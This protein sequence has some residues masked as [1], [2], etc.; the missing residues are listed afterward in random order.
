MK[1]RRLPTWALSCLLLALS[2]PAALAQLQGALKEDVRRDLAEIDPEEHVRALSGIQS[3][4]T[5]Y[6]GCKEAEQYVYK[7][8]KQLGLANLSR[9]PFQ[10]IVPVDKGAVLRVAGRRIE[11]FSVRP[12]YVR[13]PKTG[14][15]GVS[16]PIIWG[17]EGRLADFNGKTVKGSV[18]IMEF[19]SATRWL[20]AAKLGAKAIVFIEPL[21]AFRSDAEQKYSQ[22]PA[23]VPRYY[24]ERKHLPALAAAVTGRGE[25]EFDEA[26]SL[27]V[28]HALSAGKSTA[29]LLADMIWEESTVYMLS[30]EVPGTDPQL[31]R[32]VLVCHAYYDS[33]SVVPALAPGAESACGISA[34]LEIAEF[35]LKHPPRR[36]VKLLA[37]PGH[38][39]ALAGVREYAFRTIYPHR[40]EVTQKGGEREGEPHFFIGLDLSSRHNSLAGFYKGHFYDQYEKTNE[41]KLQRIYADYSGLLLDWGEQVA[42]PGGVAEKLEFQSGIVPQ[43]GRDWRSLLPDLAAFDAEVITLSAHP[44]ITLATTGDPRNAVNTPLDTFENMEPFLANVRDQAVACAHIVKQTADIP[45]IPINDQLETVK[46]ASIFG[47]AIEQTLHAYVPTVNVPDAVAGINLSEVK[48]MMGVK[49]RCFVRSDAQGLF[50]VF[51]L[52]PGMQFVV[53][54][55]RLSP[56]DG[57]IEAVATQEL[58]KPSRLPRKEWDL[59]ETDLRLNF[60]D[61]VST[62]IYDL[63]DPLQ[64]MLIPQAEALRGESNSDVQYMVKFVG[65]G[66][67][68][69]S[70]AEPVAVFF[71]KRDRRLKFILTGGLAGNQGV[72]LNIPV[73]LEQKKEVAS[74][75]KKEA[76]E[77]FLGK[78]FLADQSENFVYLT[79][80]Q[81]AM[82]MH[83]LD[84]HRLY[85][86][87]KT[88]I[89]KENI[90]KLHKQAAAH[91]AQ[92]EQMLEV[93]QYD[94]FYRETRMAWALEKRVYPD[95]RGTAHDV[96]RGVIFYFALLLP[97]VVFAERLLINYVDI[98]KKL[99]AIG[100]LFAV[101]Y[102]VL[103]FVHPAFRLSKTPIIILDGFFMVVAS[104][105]TITYLIMKFQNVMEHIKRH[106]HTIHRADVARA[107][108]AMAAFILGISNMRKRKIRTLLTALT[109]ILL[110]FTILS[111]TSFETM[112]AR[113]LRYA[114]SEPAPY[115]GVLVRSLAWDA[116]SE[117]ETADVVN[118]FQTEGMTVAPRSWFVS[119]NKAEELKLEIYRADGRGRA[120]ASAM[121][122]LSPEERE[123]S[124]VVE[125]LKQGEWFDPDSEDWPFLCVLPTAMQ[126]T[127]GIEE[128][129]LGSASVSVLGRRLRVVGV[130]D[131]RTLFNY[132]DLDEEPITPVDFVEQQYKMGQGGQGG[133]GPAFSATGEMKADDF[134]NRMRSQDEESLYI[135][136]D[137]DRVLLIPNELCVKLGGTLRSI[138]VGPARGGA[139]TGGRSFM[140]S[141]TQFAS[142]VNMA[143]YAGVDGFI[144]RVA[145]RSRLS[146][147]GLKGLLVPILIAALIVFNT[148]LGAVHER[149]TEIKVYAA[150][151]LAPIHIAALF[152]AESCVFAVVGAM[153]GYLLGQSISFLLIQVPWL[154]EGISLNYSSVSAVWSALLVIAV[155]L[156]S[157]AY[158]ARMAGKLSVPDETRKMVIAKPTSDVWEIR[159]PFT[160]SSREALG[161]MSYLRQYFESND[162]DSVGAFTCD[163]L[164]FGREEAEGLTRLAL[165]ADVWVAPLDMGISQGVKIACSPDPEE[166]A[167]SYLY[168]TITRKSGEFAT[169]HRMNM[170]FL[171]D[172]RKQLLIWRLVTAEEKQR[173]AEEGEAIL[174]GELHRQT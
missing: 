149:V 122:G 99:V 144:N 107:S 145:T 96:V 60:F 87:Q 54:G 22:V 6:P 124:P 169:W 106:I 90:W 123:F 16:G 94:K 49:G 61:C 108:A 104:I 142:R 20:N 52:T 135:H 91:L 111:F 32:E 31:S 9:E 173:L 48:S 140:P 125:Y 132:E 102:L 26:Q 146:M 38:F 159:F 148:M 95:V 167:I 66:V 85:N 97:F 11:V 137:P 56:S 127:L 112:P 8:F 170:G 14:E 41:I 147:S 126:E 152:F 158:P 27:E 62:T 18:V 84:Y 57:T 40:D 21:Q 119:R 103:R 163:N 25:D 79:A 15:T 74:G 42:G 150:V 69:T 39:Q 13:T 109:L 77:L 136:M 63:M 34:Q 138:A 45:V 67:Q 116:L 89:R 28:I 155:V 64:L 76:E 174:R 164:R 1:R 33:T 12:N 68:G 43:Y 65:K 82:D 162:E 3:R 17:G 139:E 120:I 71:S 160:V 46:V 100:G 55:F 113:M 53:D 171:K 44:A 10:I 156:A 161:V 133:A 110:T 130:V 143:L 5:G 83:L 121:L 168:F 51:G 70:Y 30:G 36:T 80:Y 131:S 29:T 59:R 88:A 4:F 7:H 24:L 172:L 78:G 92:A 165:G 37:T 117:F 58:V 81:N 75:P 72:L 153:M 166:P 93:K 86:L 134:I 151:G 129:E 101:S 154:M 19:N 50:E 23:P 105:W 114:S 141:L 118:H 47:R 98:R 2:V 128:E 157:T 73:G 115:T 35:L